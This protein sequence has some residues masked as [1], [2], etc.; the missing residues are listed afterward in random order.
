MLMS[1]HLELL[2][3]EKDGEI[4]VKYDDGCYKLHFFTKPNAVE[5]RKPPSVKTLGEQIIQTAE[6]MLEEGKDREEFSIL[7]SSA[8]TRFGVKSEGNP[9]GLPEIILTSEALFSGAIPFKITL[10]VTICAEDVHDKE[11][12]VRLWCRM[13]RIII[14]K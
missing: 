2:S 1:K 12:W 9:E 11:F 8:D 4:R 10:P 6:K 13:R 5:F 14:P 7:L 3:I